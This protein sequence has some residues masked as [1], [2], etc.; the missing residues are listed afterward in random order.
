MPQLNLNL[1]K[2]HAIKMCIKSII[3]SCISNLSIHFEKRFLF[4]FD[5]KRACVG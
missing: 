1:T 2:L 4:V 3:M 5:M